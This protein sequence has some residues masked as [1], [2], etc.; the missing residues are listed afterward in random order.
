MIPPIRLLPLN[1]IV[2]IHYRHAFYK[3]DFLRC[4][5]PPFDL[6]CPILRWLDHFLPLEPTFEGAVDVTE[7][8]G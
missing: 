6:T 3:P 5:Q 4:V 1:Q 2:H 8:P 7:V